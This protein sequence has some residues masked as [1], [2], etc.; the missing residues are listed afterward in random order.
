MPFAAFLSITTS[1]QVIQC[2]GSLIAPRVILTAA[3]CLYTKSGKA[4]A[5]GVQVVIGETDMT[6]AKKIYKGQAMTKPTAFSPS[7]KGGSVYGDV[8]L[9]YLTSASSSAPIALDDGT[10]TKQGGWFVTAG[11]GKTESSRP[12]SSLK[13]AA[14]PGISSSQYQNFVSTFKSYTG[15]VP[16]KMP[17]DHFAAGLSDSGADSCEG[18]SGGPLF[19]PGSKFSNSRSNQDVLVGVVSYGLTQDCGTLN[20]GYYTS[21][22]Y[23]NSWIRNTIAKNNWN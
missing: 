22:A 20:I 6:Q 21:V 2:G 17:A 10:F 15:T 12:T 13:W 16:P 3:H 7:G 19:V 18:D 11:W 1:N 4:S 9:I 23:W 14:V 5:L 8:A